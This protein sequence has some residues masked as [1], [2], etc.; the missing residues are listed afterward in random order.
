[1][2]AKSRPP[3]PPAV[4]SDGDL[5]SMILHHAI[6]DVHILDTL[7]PSLER[8]N[9]RLLTRLS[10]QLLDSTVHSYLDLRFSAHDALDQFKCDPVSQQAAAAVQRLPNLK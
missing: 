1:M 10:R 6:P 9:L 3:T 2:D 5:L 4:L 8:P 7:N